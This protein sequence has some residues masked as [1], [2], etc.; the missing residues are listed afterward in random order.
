MGGAVIARTSDDRNLVAG[1]S[2][3]QKIRLLTG[4]RP[5]SLHGD[6]SIWLRAVDHDIR[7]CIARMNF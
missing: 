5:W 4:S 1:L 2:A 6:G 3:G 7:A